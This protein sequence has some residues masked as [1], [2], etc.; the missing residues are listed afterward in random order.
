VRS[1]WNVYRGS[2]FDN[3]WTSLFKIHQKNYRA[4]RRGVTISGTLDFVYDDGDGPVLY[5][6]K[7]PSNVDSKKIYG[8]GQGYRRQVQAYL[9][10]AHHNRE[11]TDI[12]SARVLMVGGSGVAVENVP[13]WT[14]MLEAYLW[15]RAFVLD[16]ALRVGSPISLPPAEEGW[17]CSVDPEGAPYCPADLHFR[18]TCEMAKRKDGS[19]FSSEFLINRFEKSVDP[20]FVKEMKEL[21]D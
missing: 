20:N 10:L 15:P 8:A 7:M 2:T 3:K 16:A 19:E 1:L 17:E 6:L 4:N 13:E 21:L 14:D 9:A 12:H 5:D 18:K 11:L